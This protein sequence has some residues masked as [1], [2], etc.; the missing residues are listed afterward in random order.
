MLT[1][2]SPIILLPMIISALAILPISLCGR[3]PNLREFWT[4]LAAFGKFALLIYLLPWV[5][6]GNIFEYKLIDI[7]PNLSIAFK[8][9]GFAMLFALVASSLWIVTSIY[10][11]GYMRPLKEHGQTRFFCFFALALS[12]TMGVAFSANMF[13]MYLFYELL[14]LSTFPLVAHHQDKEARGGARKYLSYLLGT[15]VAFLLPAMIMT[16]LLTGNLDF[17]HQGVFTQ[18]PHIGLLG[19]M[20]FLYI[21][22]FAKSGLMPFHAWLPGA[23]VAPTPVSAL[24]HAVAVF[25]SRR[26][27]T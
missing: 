26:R 19:L 23:M 6:K 14:S 24:L 16:Y 7:L 13:T 18:L 3:W 1:L 8:I 2:N 22:G 27:H 9:D 10:S 4:F 15:S 5:L 20:F 12:A 21:F 11:I 17:S 25:T